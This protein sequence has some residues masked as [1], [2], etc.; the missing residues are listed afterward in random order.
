LKFKNYNLS[1]AVVGNFQFV[2]EM[3]STERDE[4][5]VEIAH[6][7]VE[8][9]GTATKSENSEIRLM[10]GDEEDLDGKKSGILCCRGKGFDFPPSGLFKCLAHS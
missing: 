5:V 1:I 2:W 4:V 10:K 6:D 7:D 9:E 8:D 3:A